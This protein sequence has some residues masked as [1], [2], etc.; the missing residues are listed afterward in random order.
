MTRE[1]F[2]FYRSYWEAVKRLRKPADRLSALE[3]IAAYALDGEERDLTDAADAIFVLIRPVLDSAAKKSKGGKASPSTEEDI[4]KISASDDED[5]DNKKKNKKKKEGEK[6][7][8]CYI[9][10]ARFVRPSL[11][12][13]AAYCLERGGIVDPQRWYAYYESNGWKV[14]KNAMKDWR[15]AVRTWERNGV[16]KPKQDKPKS[17]ADMWREEQQRDAI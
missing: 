11:D 7:N 6:E 12:D 1:Q 15:A 10:P 14:G 16:D 13:V 4:D 2:T 5:I 8:E 3:A 9:A 17:F